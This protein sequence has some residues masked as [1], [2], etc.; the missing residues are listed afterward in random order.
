MNGHRSGKNNR[1]TL[2]LKEWDDRFK[3]QAEWTLELRHYLNQALKQKP[4]H[5]VLEVGCGTGVVLKEMQS[6]TNG[7]CIGLDID[8]PRLSFGKQNKSINAAINADGN[9]I[10]FKNNSFD[11]VYGHFYL[12]WIKN[13]I[14]TLS[15]MIRILNPGGR[16][17]LM[18]E[19]DYG[20]RIDSPNEL[21]VIGSIQIKSLQRQG[22]NPFIGREL[23]SLLKKSGLSNLSTGMISWGGIKPFSLEDFNDEWK[24]IETDLS[25]YLSE[26]EIEK[27]KS[28]DLQASRFGTR[29]GFT[30]TFYAWGIKS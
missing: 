9:L 27:L 3:H 15:E 22:A 17:V 30:P 25:G 24:V 2:T 21:S 14:T 7:I 23:V 16:L 12:L 6:Q 1:L 19:P 10:P 4:F 13:P 11:L 8:L 18:A 20:G 29:I 26:H 28:I 5:R